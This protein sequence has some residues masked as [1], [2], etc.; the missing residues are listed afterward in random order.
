M[1]DLVDI[2]AS[3]TVHI[4]T[5]SGHGDTGEPTWN[6]AVATTGVVRQTRRLVSTN[7]GDVYAA[8][9][10]VLLRTSETVADGMQVSLDGGTTYFDALQ[11]NSVRD[12]IGT[13]M[14][15]EVIV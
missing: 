13:L 12:V 2:Y 4:R 7:K 9:Y 10:R 1:S 15:Y 8:A 5:R 6:S 3:V 14:H 11:V